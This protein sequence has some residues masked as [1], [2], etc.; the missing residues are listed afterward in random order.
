MTDYLTEAATAH[1][2]ALE[3]QRAMRDAAARREAAVRAAYA[4][5]VGVTEIRK[6]LG[7]HR[8]RVYQML[9]KQP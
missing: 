5:G 8:S 2:E 9:E 7:V 3:H 4:A 1:R 6:A